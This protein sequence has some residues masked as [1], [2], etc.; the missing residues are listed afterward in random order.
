MQIKRLF[1]ERLKEIREIRD[2]SVSYIAESVGVSL[3]SIYKMESGESFCTADTLGA[4]CT[5][6]EVEPYQFFLREDTDRS[7]LVDSIVILLCGV[8]DAKLVML[9][10]VIKRILMG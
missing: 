7:S 5:V 3:N 8:E 2:L 6:L 9:R 4:L 1:G 10:D